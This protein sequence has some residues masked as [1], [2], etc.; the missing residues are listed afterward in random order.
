MT[1]VPKFIRRNTRLAA[2]IERIQRE[3]IPEYS[4]LAVREVLTNALVHADY[5][6]RGMN[7]RVAI[8]SDRLEIESPGMLPFGYTLENFMSGVSHVRNKVI[9]RVFRELKIMEEWGT[10]YKRIVDT[11]RSNG[12]ITPAWEEFGTAVRVSFQP[13]IITQGEHK[14][15]PKI[16]DKDLT[17]RQ[18][19]ILA[20][21]HYD[22][23]LTS[24]EIL[25]RLGY[26][27]SNRTL[28]SDLLELKNMSLLKTLGGGPSTCWIK[29]NI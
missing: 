13:H 21:F 29:I 22:E 7:P 16:A 23:R 18:K 20:T 26:P 11:C 19:E 3:D 5:S 17:A 14:I 27:L 10:G 12:Y 9:S 6:I 2:K 15:V 24:K 1:E 28:R 4:S 25:D 8:F